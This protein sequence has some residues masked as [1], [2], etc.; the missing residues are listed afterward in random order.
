MFSVLHIL[1]FFY[2]SGI[3]AAKLRL[4]LGPS[5]FLDGQFPTIRYGHGFHYIDGRLFSLMGH[6]LA[7]TGAFGKHNLNP[8]VSFI[9]AMY[10]NSI[11]GQRKS[12][13]N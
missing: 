7:S 8:T 1:L 6:G 4:W 2:P 9:F 13:N 12:E 10:V 3:A 11:F 5:G